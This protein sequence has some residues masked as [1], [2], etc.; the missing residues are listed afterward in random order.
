MRCL[1]F[2]FQTQDGHLPAR[3]EWGSYLLVF[4]NQFFSMSLQNRYSLVDRRPTIDR[5]STQPQDISCSL[6]GPYGDG[7]YV[8]L[9]LKYYSNSVKDHVKMEPNDTHRT[10]LLRHLTNIFGGDLI[11]LEGEFREGFSPVEV[12]SF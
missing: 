4:M 12:Y 5:S 10:D 11:V 2:K 9:D 7:L 3:S 1:G 8:V 6:V